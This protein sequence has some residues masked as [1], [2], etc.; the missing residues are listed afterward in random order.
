MKEYF[1]EYVLSAKT[2]VGVVAIASLTF[3]V[4]EARETTETNMRVA[5]EGIRSLDE[6][7]LHQYMTRRI[8]LWSDFENA[9][10]ERQR[11]VL[12][13]TDWSRFYVQICKH[14]LLEFEVW[15]GITYREGVSSSL[16]PEFR[17]YT[18]N[19]CR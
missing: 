10:F 5:Q 6:A 4:V 17:L 1:Q 16:T 8:S 19:S 18:E 13:D 14:Y 15:E 7:E 11:G 9:Y 2:L 12:G 3:L